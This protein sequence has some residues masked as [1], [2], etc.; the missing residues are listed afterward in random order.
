MAQVRKN[1]SS[2]HIT[3][4]GWEQDSQQL[5]YPVFSPSLS[6]NNHIVSK[7]REYKAIYKPTKEIIPK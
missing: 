3:L 6:T 5:N 1:A 7:K 2:A 4:V